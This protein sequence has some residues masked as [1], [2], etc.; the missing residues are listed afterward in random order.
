MIMTDEALKIWYDIKRKSLQS[1]NAIEEI[2]GEPLGDAEKL[3]IL[4]LLQGL[5][6]HDKYFINKSNNTIIYNLH[7]ALSDDVAEKRIIAEID[8]ITNLEEGEIK[9]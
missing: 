8:E 5:T 3:I 2:F 7:I 6:E 9:T 4:R 1:L